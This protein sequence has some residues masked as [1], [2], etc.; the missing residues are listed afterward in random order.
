MATTEAY[1]TIC[2]RTPAVRDAIVAAVSG[3]TTCSS[4]TDTDLAGITGYLYLGNGKNIR[5]KAGDFSGLTALT[6]LDLSGNNLTRLPSGIFDPLTALTNL[7]LTDTGLSSLPVG[8]F[9]QLTSLS[10]LS[11]AYNDLTMLPPGIFDKLTALTRLDLYTSGLTRLPSGIFDPLTALTN[12]NLG[13]NS[14]SS[15]PAGTFDQLTS[16][17]GLYLDYNQLTT[18]SPDIF[19]KLTSLETLSLIES[20]LTCLPFIPTSV[21]ALYV[22]GTASN[23][24]TCGAGVT[25]SSSSLSVI[26]GSTRTYT[27]ALEARP[28]RYANSGNVA[29]TT[30]SS[31]TG[32]ATVSPATLTFSTSNWDTPQTVTVTG[33]AAGSSTVSHSISGGGYGSVT[34]GSVAVDVSTLSASAVTATTATLTLANH[35][36]NWYYKQTTP[37]GGVCTQVNNSSTANLSNLTAGTNY[38]YA[39]YSAATCSE[40]ELATASFT[41]QFATAPEAVAA[42]TVAHQ[43]S[44]LAVSWDA[45]ARATHYHVTY[46]D[47]NG[48]SWQLATLEHA[49]TSLTIN[50]VDSS[51]T[52]MVGVRAKNAAGASG[53]TN[54]AAAMLAAPDPVAVVTAV[55]QGSSLAVSWDA[56]ARATHYHVTYSSNNGASWQLVA[57]EYAGTSF[58]IGVDSKTYLV[59]VRAKNAV[60]ASGWTNS[61]AAT[62]AAPEAVASVKV[63]HQG[64]TLAGWWPAAARAD[65][66]HVT[67]SGDNGASWQLAALE[68]IGT[69]FIIN[70]VDFTINGV[71]SSKTYIV[72]VRAKNAA[73][74]SGWTNSAPATPPALSVADATTA[75]PD[76][77][78]SATLDFVVTMNGAIS[79]VSVDYATSDGTATAGADYTAASG[80]L[81]FAAGE[82]SK[83]VSV[84]VLNDA[85]DEGSET[86]TLTLSNATG[87]VIGDGE[88]TGTITN[89]GSMPQA[90]ISRFGRT[91]A[92][93][94]VDAVASRLRSEPT[95]GMEVTLAGERLGWSTDSGEGHVEQLAQWLM[96]SN[97]DTGDVGLRTIEGRELVAN[98]SFAFASPSS[99]GNLFSFWGRGAVTNFDGREGELTL[100]GEV[101]TWMLGTDWSWGQWPG[102]GEARRSTAGLLLSRSRADG[103]YDSPAGASSGDVD[104]T[105]TGVFPWGSHRFTDRLAVWGVAGY[106]QG[107]LEVTP[108]LPTGEDDATLTADLNLWLAAAGLRGTL[109]DGGNDGLTITGTTDAMV[110]GN[111]SERVTG[112]EAA[113]ATVTRLRLGMEAHRPF[114]LGNPESG[115]GAGSGAVLTPSLELGLRH[116]G[117]DAETGFGLD[118]GGGMVL[119]HPERGLEVE[120]RG[121]G[122]L[123]H[124]AEGFQDRGFSGSLSWRQKPDSDLG[125]ALS[126]SQTMG[127]SSS[128]G[129]D[130]LLSRVTLEGLAANDGDD[131][132][133]NQRLDLQLSY[134]FLAFGDR[135]TLTPELGLGFYD[136]GRDYH[137]GWRLTRLAE[138]GAFDLSFDVTRRESIN[139]DGTA[140]DHGVQLEVNTRF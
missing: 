88:A 101:T 65:S 112:L 26:V 83:T 29:V 117:G 84:P 20:S 35:T 128:G 32:K 56:P 21:T 69:N 3:K 96:V 28:N 47:S 13:V 77:G 5:L 42:V 73:G 14:L 17:I 36:G 103:G 107:E 98:S 63:V 25:L 30:S 91:V 41:T 57:L 137:I 79:A 126:L 71:D 82:T 81:T 136:S 33:V 23:Y 99:G 111:T 74:Y 120:L 40:N 34:V 60:G 123:T 72:G 85:H 59:A 127:G 10:W 43:G 58:T 110:V 80:T 31:A 97:G 66:Y 4:I 138:T 6:Y 95:P 46:T 75:E 125:A 139:N 1:E 53:W 109:L 131:E 12:L 132:L 49:G 37:A 55:H 70:S 116:D 78:Q 140:P 61:A 18:L 86:L 90:W 2:N 134:G 67:Y 22:N 119:S 9:D 130:A 45:P 19:D 93:Q 104:A 27:L 38:T 115:T 24:A 7:N 15:L 122:L 54:S 48:A 135:F 133:K 39:T 108:K 92:D 89:A 113:Q 129:A 11:L 102:G 62:L 121:R 52:Y 118:L 87:A 100:D 51:K 124:A 50:G 68:H 16:L 105:L 106:G 8:I 94:V 76:A 64:S 114:A 44:S